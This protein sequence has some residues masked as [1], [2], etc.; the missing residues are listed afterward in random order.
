MASTPTATPEFYHLS[1]AERDR[2]WRTIRAEMGR[3]GVDCLL[4]VGNSGRWNEMH[5]N[6]R[7]VCDYADNLS[8]IGY[9]IFPRE[10]EG[11]LLVQGLE[12]IDGTPVI[13]IKP[14][15]PRAGGW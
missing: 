9:L 15:L 13:D 7:Y 1:E 14:A 3:R 4:V 2:R 11:T 8:G 6:I 5:A 12:A 10:G